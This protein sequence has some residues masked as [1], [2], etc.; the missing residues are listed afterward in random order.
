MRYDFNLHEKRE[1]AR[2]GSTK[3]RDPQDSA[4]VYRVTDLE[5]GRDCGYTV[6]YSVEPETTSIIPSNGKKCRRSVVARF[7]HGREMPWPSER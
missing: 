1:A 6:G 3:V 4:F 2:R 7:F 5:S